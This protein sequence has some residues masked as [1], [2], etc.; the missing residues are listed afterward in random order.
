MKSAE[1]KL[2]FVKVGPM[3]NP[4]LMVTISILSPSGSVFWKSHAAFSARVFDF[5]YGL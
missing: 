1:E 4:G 5:S 3:I 2:L